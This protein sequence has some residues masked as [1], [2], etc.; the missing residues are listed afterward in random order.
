MPD[1]VTSLHPDHQELKEKHGYCADI[2]AT[3]RE[4][5]LVLDRELIV[6]TANRAFYTSFQTTPGQTEG[7]PVDQVADG[8]LSSPTLRG[9]LEKVLVEGRSFQ[10]FAIENDHPGGELRARSG[11]YHYSH[12]RLTS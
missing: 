1:L 10:D 2:L 8:L 7:R 3:L 12:V 6:K 5:F 9:S 11:P 4:P